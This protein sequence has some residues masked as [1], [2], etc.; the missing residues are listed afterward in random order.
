MFDSQRAG[1]ATI[2]VFLLGGAAILTTVRE[3]TAG[4]VAAPPA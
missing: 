4:A 2:L 3:P 1:M